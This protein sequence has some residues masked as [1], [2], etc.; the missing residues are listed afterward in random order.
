MSP[1]DPLLW[2][3]DRV[4]RLF[5]FRYRLEIYTPQHKRQHGYYVL[6]FL[7]KDRLVARLDL[8]ADRASGRLMVAAAFCEHGLRPEI[9]AEALSPELSAMSA[10]LGLSETVVGPNGNLA[11]FLTRSAERRGSGGGHGLAPMIE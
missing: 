9:V 8:K 3:R 5:G 11:P 6:P 4:E 10:W 2:E 7:L 1:F